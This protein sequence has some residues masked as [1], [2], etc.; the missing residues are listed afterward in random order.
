MSDLP[1][2][3]LGVVAWNDSVL[4]VQRRDTEELLD[5]SQ[6]TWALPG[7]KKEESETSRAACIREVLE[8]TG[9][10]VDPLR[11][12]YRGEHPNAPVIAS[13]WLCSYLIA[14]PRREVSDPKILRSS[15]VQRLRVKQYLTSTL[16][17]CVARE[18]DL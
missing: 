12:L 13:F 6:L 9:F 10:R 2:I 17:E 14:T 4:L 15:W 1:E 8:E 16:N 3:S 18:L 5:G 7:G 11:L